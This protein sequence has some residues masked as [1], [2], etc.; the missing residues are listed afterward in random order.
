MLSIKFYKKDLKIFD[1][2]NGGVPLHYTS[3][4]TDFKRKSH[5]S[6]LILTIR[7]SSNPAEFLQ[8]LFAFIFGKVDNLLPKI[9]THRL[10]AG[11]VWLT[12]ASK[13]IGLGVQI[14]KGHSH[15]Y[16]QYLRVVK[17]AEKQNGIHSVTLLDGAGPYSQSDSLLTRRSVFFSSE[18]WYPALSNFFDFLEGEQKVKIRI[19]GHYK[20]SYESSSE[21][22]GGREV[23]YGQTPEL[24][25]SSQFVLTRMSTAVSFAVLYRKPILF[26]Y[27]DQL[28]KD[29]EFMGHILGFS[30]LLGT[31]PIN[32]D[33][34]PKN[35]N[36]YLKV[37]EK[38]YEQYIHDVLTSKPLGEP[39]YEI[40]LKDIMGI[41]VVD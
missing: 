36:P 33:H 40:I 15:D 12:E 7:E 2:Y 32:I 24:V 17:S 25:E 39:N 41:K 26:I 19:A 10:V 30:A 20:T 11:E 1:L 37:N 23:I 29:S 6:S 18:V 35:I 8:K 9:L 31:Y 27:S 28:L 3:E 21:L 14:V 38:L 34:F 16:S 4:I 13:N 22:F 5:L